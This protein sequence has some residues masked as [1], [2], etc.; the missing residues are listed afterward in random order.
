MHP[1]SRKNRKIRKGKKGT[2]QSLSL[3]L[4]KN[5]G[6]VAI[7][8]IDNKTLEVVKEIPSQELLDIK[9]RIDD[10]AEALFNKSPHP[11]FDKGG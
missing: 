9:D 4:N 10:M 2:G 6:E 7:K 8:I 3:Y 11:P 1:N 5:N